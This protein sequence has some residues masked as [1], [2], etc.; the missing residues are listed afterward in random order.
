M[1]GEEG[2]A[3]QQDRLAFFGKVGA[4]FFLS[5]EL[6]GR[7]EANE[8]R[9]DVGIRPFLA[10]AAALAAVWAA[11]RSRRSSARAAWASST[12]PD[13]RGSSGRPR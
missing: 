1:P 10:A 5:S 12:G 4:L 9:L 2:R 6:A 8:W 3:F 13:T 11:C 7:Y